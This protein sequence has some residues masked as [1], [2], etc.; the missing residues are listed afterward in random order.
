MYASTALKLGAVS[1]QNGLFVIGLSTQKFTAKLL[2]VE[3]GSVWGLGPDNN[4]SKE[5]IDATSSMIVGPFDSR[6][7][8]ELIASKGLLLTFRIST[9][10]T[11][12]N[13]LL[14]LF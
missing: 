10:S 1:R 7:S 9:T 14:P 12:P 6:H 5:Q 4:L 11:A 2:V 8:P 3:H 13:K